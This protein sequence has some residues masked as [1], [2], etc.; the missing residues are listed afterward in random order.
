MKAITGQQSFSDYRLMSKEHGEG[1][2]L[3]PL[4]G[5]KPFMAGKV[6]PL[7]QGAE[8]GGSRRI[9]EVRKLRFPHEILETE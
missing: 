9:R 7:D 1:L 4:G 5:E 3:V 8:F 2:P 6:D